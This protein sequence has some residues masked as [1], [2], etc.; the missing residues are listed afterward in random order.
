MATDP[1]TDPARADARAFLGALL[2]GDALETA[3][4]ELDEDVGYWGD[5]DG[6]E[7]LRA[8]RSV[9]HTHAKVSVEAE[10]SVLLLDL[11][12][13][14]PTIAAVLDTEP[15]DVRRIAIANGLDELSDADL[16]AVPAASRPT[17]TRPGPESR[18]PTVAPPPATEPVATAAPRRTFDDLSAPADPAP[19]TRDVPL[20]EPARGGSWRRWL[21]PLGLGAVAL[22][23]IVVMGGGTGGSVSIT[24]ARM[25]EIVD[26]NSGEPGEARTRFTVGEDV[27]LW[28]SYRTGGDPETVSITWWRIEGEDEDDLYTSSDVTL[29]DVEDGALNVAMSSLFSTEPGEYRVEVNQGDEVLV[30]L[31][32]RIE[33]P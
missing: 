33:A 10:L 18:T 32:F 8:A 26:R 27:R 31:S 5:R 24:D 15:H 9:L 20:R 19:G 6:V 2:R 29:L 22:M 23:L 25:T 4:A 12:L 7:V 13:D 14:V 30:D 16:H 21:V 17:P 28:F 1:R 11:G 3:R